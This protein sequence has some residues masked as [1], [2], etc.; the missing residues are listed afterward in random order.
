[1]ERNNIKANFFTITKPGWNEEEMRIFKPT[2]D[3]LQHQIKF[4]EKLITTFSIDNVQKN[5]NL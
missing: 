3:E 5:Y 2:L 1:M 4:L